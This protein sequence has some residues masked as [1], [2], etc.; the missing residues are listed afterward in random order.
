[1]T[2]DPSASSSGDLPPEEQ[3]TPVEPDGDVLPG[4][5]PESELERHAA[6]AVKKS[7]GASYTS[8]NSILKHDLDRVPAGEASGPIRTA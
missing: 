6:D 5:L 2:Q 1:M 7:N 4:T 8:V 3:P